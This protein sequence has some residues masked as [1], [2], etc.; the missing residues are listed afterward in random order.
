MKN[1]NTKRRTSHGGT[2]YTEHTVEF[3]I[4]NFSLCPPCS[5]CLRVSLFILLLAAV[6]MFNS[7]VSWGVASAEEYYAIGMAYY[8]LGKFEDAEKWLNRARAKDKTK[9][10]SEYNLGRI[11]FETGR[12]DDAIKHFEAI[13][14]RDPVNVLALKAAAYTYIRAGNIEKAAALYDRVLAIVPESADDG[15]NYALVLYAMEK[16]PEAEQVLKNHEFALLDNNDVLLLYARAQKEQN[17][18]EAIDSYDKWLINNTDAQVRYEYAQLLEAQEMYARAL[19]EY[20]LAMDGLPSGSVEPA[21]Q[22]VR[23]TIARVLLFADA[24]SSE[25]IAQLQEAVTEGFTDTEQIT[26]LLEDERISAANKT[27]IRAI[28]AE[29]ERAATEAAAAA[30]AEEAAAAAAEPVEEAAEAAAAAEEEI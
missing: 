18:P 8:D 5:P 3:K 15:Y 1:I 10:A 4:F 21:K 2:K 12:Y 19:E 20:R 30:A 11:A 27:E 7:C 6:V 24:G 22:D 17:K 25:G 16:Y 13:L 9:S 14:K 28:I 29:L 26:A 23:F